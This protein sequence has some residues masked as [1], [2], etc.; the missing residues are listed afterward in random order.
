MPY[1]SHTVRH[2]VYVPVEFDEA[3]YK[4]VLKDRWH[5]FENRP[6]RDAS[7]MFA[8][9]RKVVNTDATRTYAIETLLKKHPRLIV[10]YNFNYELELLR[11]LSEKIG[12]PT[13]E[14]N[15]HKHQSIPDTKRWLY[16][17]QFTAGAEG[18]NCV[19]TDAT[20]F[21]SL[22]YAYR[23]TEQAKGRIDRLNTPFVDLYC[24]VLRSKSTLDVAILKALNAKKN[25]NE[26]K[27]SN[28]WPKTQI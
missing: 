18:W 21:W 5:I 8:L 13:G 25:F 28:F 23:K 12:V 3:L 26:A 15:G 1:I 10:F 7:E 20:A 16:L 6:I 19:S 11:E 2:T 22:N 14:W 9:L 24:Y 17:V 27:T 4:R